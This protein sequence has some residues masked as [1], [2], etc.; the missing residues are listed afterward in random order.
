M[1][2]NMKTREQFYKENIDTI[3]T[4]EDAVFD[5][6]KKMENEC[7]KQDF[8]EKLNMAWSLLYE[9]YKENK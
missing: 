6:I 4:L 5:L 1:R 3:A 9:V 2:N 8:K 7:G